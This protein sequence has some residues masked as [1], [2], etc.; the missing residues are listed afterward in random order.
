M[1]VTQQW[2]PKRKTDHRPPLG[3]LFWMSLSLFLLSY[4]ITMPKETQVYFPFDIHLNG[5]A[6]G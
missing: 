4:I 3:L 6:D 5:S 2:F 1:R